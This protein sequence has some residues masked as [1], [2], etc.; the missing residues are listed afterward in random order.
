MS[1]N[2]TTADLQGQ[3]TTLSQTI[4]NLETY[5]KSQSD[6]LHQL[7]K[8]TLPRLK[9]LESIIYKQSHDE[10]SGLFEQFF[11]RID[12]VAQQCDQRISKI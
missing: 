4:Q 7:E 11:N 10:T 2:T 8:L 1:D 9:A 5:Y 3:I 6:S 12:K